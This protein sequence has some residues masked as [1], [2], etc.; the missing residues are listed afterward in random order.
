MSKDSIEI[1]DETKLRKSMEQ[2][3]KNFNDVLT[4]IEHQQKE[5]EHQIEKMLND[6]DDEQS[7]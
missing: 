6:F 3:Q 2:L 7:E 1:K 5:T 4:S